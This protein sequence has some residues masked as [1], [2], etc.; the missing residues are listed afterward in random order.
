MAHVHRGIHRPISV[1]VA[2]V[3][4]VN[5]SQMKPSGFTVDKGCLCNVNS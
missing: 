3:V 4:P 2:A 5:K 1:A